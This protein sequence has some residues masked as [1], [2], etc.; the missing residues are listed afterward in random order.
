MKD[1]NYFLTKEQ[2]YAQEHNDNKDWYYDESIGEFAYKSYPD[3]FLAQKPFTRFSKNMENE[4][5][6]TM[7]ESYGLSDV[8]VVVLRCFLG[9]MSVYFREDTYIGFDSIP[10]VAREMQLILDSVISKAPTHQEGTVLYRFL[11]EHDQHEFNVGDIFQPSHSVTCTTNKW[12]QDEYTYIITPLSTEATKAHDLY[13]ICNHGNE[14][15]VNFEKGTKFKVTKVEP[16][17]QYK[18]IY[19]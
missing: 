18:Y 2:E 9:N 12:N 8:E 6:R 5:I 1:L 17:G 19:I 10:E 15:Q 13:K 16:K 11:K 7:K 14:N 3:D 4:E